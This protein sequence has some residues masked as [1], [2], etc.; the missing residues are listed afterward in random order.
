M[1]R[2]STQMLT[3]NTMLFKFEAHFIVDQEP[4]IDLT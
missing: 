3:E 4:M 1:L 2:Y